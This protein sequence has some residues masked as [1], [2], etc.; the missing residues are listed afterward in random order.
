M[1]I[2]ICALLRA[3]LWDSGF[4]HNRICLHTEKSLP[5]PKALAAAGPRLASLEEREE[6]ARVGPG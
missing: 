1:V 6:C 4:A 2:V 5:H 3:Y